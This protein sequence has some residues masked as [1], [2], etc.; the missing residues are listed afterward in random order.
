MAK[1]QAP[2]NYLHPAAR[3]FPWRS[4]NKV[5]LFIDG[6]T[7]YPE[8]ITRIDQATSSVMLEMYLVESGKI[9]DEFIRCLLAAANR[10]V[11]VYLLFDAIGSMGFSKKDRKRLKISNI[12]LTF[13]NPLYMGRIRQ[14]FFRDHR[15]ILIV[16]QQIVFVGGAGITDDF[17]SSEAQK[18]W[19]ET[20]VSVRGECLPDWVALFNSV[21][22]IHSTKKIILSE[23]VD[24]DKGLSQT[25]RVVCALGSQQSTKEG[26][27]RSLVKRIRNAENRIWIATAYF[28]PSF[29]I[30]RALVKA[31][32]RGIDVRILLPGVHSD[33]PSI[34]YA[35]RRFYRRLLN[36]GVQIFEYESRFMHQKVLLCDQWV[37][38][39]SSNIDRWNFYW[40]LE[41]NLEVEDSI[42]SSQIET[43]LLQDISDSNKCDIATWKQRDLV[44][45][46]KEWFWGKVDKWL[47]RKIR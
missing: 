5:Q 22:K 32:Q 19:R 11:Q 24:P 35:G 4:H 38:I 43:M 31:A 8:M 26:I 21:W 27:K 41:A 17:I 30:R 15:K 34:H 29:K 3:Q 45:R 33:H 10:G 13:Y 28:L 39:G 9:A 6:D 40:N 7:F 25:C 2:L 23:T 18:G 36:A 46:F 20:M 12:H 37:S 1:Q 16:D 44:S 47:N 14:N 42:F